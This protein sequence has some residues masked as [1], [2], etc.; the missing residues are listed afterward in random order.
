M[1]YHIDY[2]QFFKVHH[3]VLFSVAFLAISLR[4][5]TYALTYF[6]AVDLT[7][8]SQFSIYML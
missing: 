5:I 3:L 7:D 6:I 1:F 2:M 4:G 8:T